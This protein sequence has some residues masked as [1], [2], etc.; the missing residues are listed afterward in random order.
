[1]YEQG[2][3][4]AAFMLAAMKKL[5]KKVGQTYRGMR[6][7]LAAFNSNYKVGA[8]STDDAFVSQ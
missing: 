8:V 5:P 7:T 6:M 1:M 3:L 2:A 4:H